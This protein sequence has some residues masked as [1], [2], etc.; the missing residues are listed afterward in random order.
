MSSRC[1]PLLLNE[2]HSQVGQARPI[3]DWLPHRT[4]YLDEFLR[5]DGRGAYAGT[6]CLHCEVNTGTIRCRDCFS[7]ELLCSE[8]VLRAHAR[9]PFHRLLVSP[10]YFYL[11]VT[12]LIPGQQW[13][14]SYFE[15]LTLGTLGFKLSLG[16]EL[17]TC[18]RPSAPVKDFTIVDTNGIHTFPVS[19][20]ECSNR[21]HHRIQLL[22]AGLMP[23]SV[24]RP[25]SAFT[26]DVLETFHLLTLQSKVSAYDFYYSIEHKTNNA[27]LLNI[28]VRI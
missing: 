20:C 5:C 14:G 24:E 2:H 3:Q 25:R 12:M 4:A 28:K 13:T 21:P 1:H 22:R 6:L 15:D 11:L 18:T 26:F 7:D 8:C 17:G 10:T 19:F 16:H 23:A 9:L 27:G